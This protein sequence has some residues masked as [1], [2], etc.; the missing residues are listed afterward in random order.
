MLNVEVVGEL[1]SSL[2]SEMKSFIEKELGDIVTARIY[3][4]G[5]A[6]QLQLNE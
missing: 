2:V 4:R 1:K 3:C 5:I 6:G